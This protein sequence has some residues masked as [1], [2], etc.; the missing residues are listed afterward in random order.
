MSVLRINLLPYFTI[1]PIDARYYN[2]HFLLHLMMP[3]TV[4]YKNFRAH[5]RKILPFLERLTDNNNVGTF[6]SF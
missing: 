5:G 4:N 1:F 6:T 2:T 3:T